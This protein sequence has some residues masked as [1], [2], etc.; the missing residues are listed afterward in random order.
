M[1]RK[2]ASIYWKELFLGDVKSPQSHCSVPFLANRNLN[3]CG[4]HIDSKLAITF[5]FVGL[6]YVFH[7]PIHQKK[8]YESGNS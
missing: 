3:G 5:D 7:N 2:F 1:R 4:A 6:V 8:E